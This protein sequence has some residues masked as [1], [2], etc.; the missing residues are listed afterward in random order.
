MD[1]N[2]LDLRLGLGFVNDTPKRVIGSFFC[3]RDSRLTSDVV[4]KVRQPPVSGKW[5]DK[6]TLFFCCT[7]S[8]KCDSCF[9]FL[10][11]MSWRR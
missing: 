9:W 3:R 8:F 7:R 4:A 10:I 5:V 6:T 2:L 1:E 11:A